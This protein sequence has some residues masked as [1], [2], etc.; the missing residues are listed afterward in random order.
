MRS[1]DIT[2]FQ[3]RLLRWYQE[4]RRR[5]PWRNK[6]ASTYAKII[7]EILLQRTR[8]ETIATFYPAFLRQFPT[9]RALAEA[10]EQ[11]LR[12]Y[13]QPIGLWRRR[14][15]TLVKLA[16]EMQRRRGIVPKDR[17]AIEALPGVGQ[18]IAN[19]I[20][21]L[22]HNTPQP[23][24]DVNMARVL[25]RHFGPRQLVD[26]RYDPYLQELGQR[27]VRGREAAAVNWAIL[28]LAA[29]TCTTARPSCPECPICA[30][31]QYAARAAVQ[32]E[33]CPPSTGRGVKWE[34]PRGH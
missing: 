31:C 28:D 1:R 27:I 14:S 23:L 24:L 22:A 6:R 8:A 16:N 30:T 11:A 9:W 15:R 20:Q 34:S 29:S 13:L 33:A 10:D 17:S 32:L 12:V 25:E 2:S 4:H 26:I 19:A 21:L 3:R 18:Y 5:F 7:A